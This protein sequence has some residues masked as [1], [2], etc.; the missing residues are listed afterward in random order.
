MSFQSRCLNSSS[1]PDASFRTARNELGNKKYNLRNHKSLFDPEDLRYPSA[2]KQTP[3]SSSPIADKSWKVNTQQNVINQMRINP[4]HV[5]FKQNPSAKQEA[6]LTKWNS[7]YG[8]P[9]WKRR[10][11]IDGNF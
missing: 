8:G 3:S 4:V 10:A 9:L 7:K 6:E 11:P 1:K 2:F 5:N